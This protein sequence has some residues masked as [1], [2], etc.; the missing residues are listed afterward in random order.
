MGLPLS[1]PKFRSSSLEPETCHLNR[2]VV[3]GAAALH[4]RIVVADVFVREL[5]AL[6]HG[7]W[8]IQSQGGAD[9]SQFH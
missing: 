3:Q 5:L 2:F 6:C 1:G 4:M 9:S 8:V 7:R